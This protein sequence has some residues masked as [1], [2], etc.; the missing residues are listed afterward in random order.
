M[1]HMKQEN[2]SVYFAVLADFVKSAQR[3]L[4]NAQKAE[5]G[6]DLQAAFLVDARL[7]FE[8]AIDVINRVAPCPY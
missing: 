3:E 2:P 7:K 6:S 5:D 4:A 8:A 1:N